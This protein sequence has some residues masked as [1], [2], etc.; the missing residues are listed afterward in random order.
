MKR[1][2][3]LLLSVLFLA[4]CVY[5]PEVPAPAS[6]TETPPPETE[7]RE[8]FP[9]A[10][11]A[12]TEEP[13]F[14]AMAYALSLTTEEKV[15]QIFLARCPDISAAKDVATYHL[16]GY[17]LFG[18]DFEENT[19]ETVR[20]NIESY[21]NNAAIPLLIAVDE[22]G[23]S[24]CRISAYPQFR[25]SRFPSPRNLYAEGGMELVLE[26]ERE[27][28]RLLSSLGINVNAAPVCD[29]TMDENAFMYSRSLGQSP[30]ITGQFV[31]EVS[32]V[33][34]KNGIGSILKH[35]PG[36]GDNVDTHT[37]IA[38]DPRPLSQ[39]E[40]NDLLPFTYGIRAGCG[41]IMVSHTVILDLDGEKPASLSPKVHQYLRNQ[42]N[43]NGVIVTDDLAMAAI[44][45][46]Y[47]EGEAAVLA[48]LAGNDLLCSSNHRVQYDAVLEAVT[49][50]RISED[51]LNQAVARVL[52]WKHDI[53]ILE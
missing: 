15:G 5:T 46:R 41:A 44:T 7:T 34:R 37:E 36:Y 53:G 52:Q 49:S 13:A 9:D 28:C 50:G 17:I 4:G 29:I 51:L 8:T 45:Q 38:V 14:D 6:P 25:T 11:T 31:A 16:G 2:F 35:F 47:G 27:K 1:I 43:F 39:L 42:M 32:G 10:T 18:K 30:E 40:A 26:T 19:P 23:G 33:M 3:A 22:E 12:G 21:Q 24:V 20:S 48:V